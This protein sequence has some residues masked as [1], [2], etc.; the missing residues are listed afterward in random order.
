MSITGKDR[1]DKLS[2]TTYQVILLSER[3]VCEYNSQKIDQSQN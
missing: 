3:N 1:H 2:A